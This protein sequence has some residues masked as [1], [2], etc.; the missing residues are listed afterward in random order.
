MENIYY[1]LKESITVID[2]LFIS[3]ILYNLFSGIKNGLIASLISFLKWIIAF[4]AV[5]YFLPVIRPYVDGILPSEIMTDIIFG[6]LIFFFTLFLVLLINKGIKKT[7]NWSG[8]G[9]IDTIF[10]CIF[11]IVKGY[12]YFVAVFA[13]INLAHPYERWNDSL[14]NGIAFGIILWGNELVVETF[15]KRYEYIDKSKKK[16]EKLK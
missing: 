2:I 14:N 9:S 1:S 16:L 12:I 5:K 11:G 7:G 13:V 10:G 6:S 15:P 4:L 8:L 3:F